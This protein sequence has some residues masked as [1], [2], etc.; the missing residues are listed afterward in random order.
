MKSILSF[1]DKLLFFPVYVLCAF[2]DEHNKEFDE[3][4]SK[5]IEEL[6]S[7]TIFTI[8]LPIAT[9]T[10]VAILNLFLSK[11]INTEW[12][13]FV[14]NGSLP[15]IAFGIISSAISYLVEQLNAAKS[16]IFD[17]RKRIT[18]V[19]LLLLFLTSI[20]FLVQSITVFTFNQ[21]QNTILLGVTILLTLYS[22][23]LGRHMYLLQSNF[24]KGYSES[25]VY[26]VENMNDSLEQQFGAK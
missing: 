4:R 11:S 18:A 17:M 10:S 7:W 5:N 12:H 2:T 8:A 9:F 15:I 3:I 23:K 21:S 20:L 24:V 26:N 14:N 25:I 13:R 22:I 6:K 1:I 19:G 16:H